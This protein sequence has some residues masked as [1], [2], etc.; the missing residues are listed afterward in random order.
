MRA[1]LFDFAHV[2]HG[3]QRCHAGGRDG[4]PGSA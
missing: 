3:D 1:P 2:I 4:N